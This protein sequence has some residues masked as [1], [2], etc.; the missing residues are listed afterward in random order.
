MKRENNILEIDWTR[1]R[2][3]FQPA[4]TCIYIK[5]LIYYLILNLF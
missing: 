3:T 2:P 5:L 1:N 4:I